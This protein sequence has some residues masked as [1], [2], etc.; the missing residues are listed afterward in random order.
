MLNVGTWSPTI[1]VPRRQPRLGARLRLL[2]SAICVL[3][4]TTASAGVVINEIY[5]P[6]PAPDGRTLEFVELRNTGPDAVEIGGWSLRQGVQFEFPEAATLPPSR[7]AVVAGDREA[8]L[9]H[10]GLAGESVF[11]DFEGALDNEGE[12]VVLTGR[13]NAT[14]HVVLYDDAAPWPQAPAL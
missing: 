5:Y 7:Y 1:R 12:S 9:E 13:F 6:P 4:S 14:V 8:F 2:A 11:G 10:F 3:G